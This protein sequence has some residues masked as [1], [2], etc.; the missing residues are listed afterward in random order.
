MTQPAGRPSAGSGSRRDRASAFVFFLVALAVYLA[1]GA[2]CAWWGDGLELASAAWT[3]GIPHPTGYP[4]YT[5]LGHVFMRLAPDPGQGLAWMSAL[6]MAAA[7]ALLIP[8]LAD[9]ARAGQAEDEATPVGSP[10][11]SALIVAGLLALSRTAWEH[12]TF[13]EVY[14]LT[15]L[16]AVLVLF[17]AQ[18]A[19]NGGAS[20]ATVVAI[21]LL[22]GLLGLNHYSGV[23]ALPLALVG[24]TGRR[25]PAEW[26]SVA[27]ALVIAGLI[28]L[29]GLT[30]LVIRA[31]QNP[32]IN[33]GDPSTLARLLWVLTGGQFA[34]VNLGP[35]AAW[36]GLAHW[37]DW[38][39]RQ[40]MPGA[41]G[42][43]ADPVRLPTGVL[44]GWLPWRVVLGGLIVATAILGLVRLARRQRALA[45][46]LLLMMAASTGFAA[47][48]HILD[49]DGY[50]LIAL[51]AAAIGWVQAAGALM[52]LPVA[53]RTKLFDPAVARTLAGLLVSALAI[54]NW[55]W[56]DKR[57]DVAPLSWGE[58]ALELV[59][60]AGVILTQG[61]NDIYA[62]WYQQMVL[63]LRGDVTIIGSNFIFSGWYARYFERPERGG[64]I[65]RV[66]DRGIVAGKHI[67]DHALI[68]GTILPNLRAGRSVFITGG[69]PARPEFGFDPLLGD[70]FTVEPLG[71]LMTVEYHDWFTRRYL[72]TLPPAWLIRL[73]ADESVLAMSDGELELW[74]MN[75]YRRRQR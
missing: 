74:I 67:F 23:A 31:R 59:P 75:W 66:E 27:S 25:R 43:A 54:G 7:L 38:W 70:L 10:L 39:G 49:I 45:V 21:G 65:V 6:A 3:F 41:L 2:P 69:L 44:P 61:D 26:R 19:Q 18:R 16:L 63:G 57:G 32:A 33:W 34:E 11:T 9:A 20:R 5:T 48:Y 12:A 60:E 17:V 28:V 24:L 13:A 42:L 4:L 72:N 22:L 53:R 51:P 40:W 46:A 50:F 14:P 64:A 37:L 36:H 52:R 62:L 35:S 1:T 29:A 56:I 68:A 8:V 47:L 30:Y 15:F 71:P 73:Q 55:H 58:R